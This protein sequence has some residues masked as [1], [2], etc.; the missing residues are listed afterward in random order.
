MADAAARRAMRVRMVCM[1]ISLGCLPGFR[2]TGSMEM[3]V[4][5]SPPAGIGQMPT[6]AM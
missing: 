3:T 2:V 4:P 5:V 1:V 6:L